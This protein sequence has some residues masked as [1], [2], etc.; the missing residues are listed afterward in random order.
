MVFFFSDL[1]S[2]SKCRWPWLSYTHS[3]YMVTLW[4]D[5][6]KRRTCQSS[7]FVFTPRGKDPLLSN[8]YKIS[9]SKVL[10]RE[11]RNK[12]RIEWYLFSLF[13]YLFNIEI[14]CVK[15]KIDL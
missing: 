12:K 10:L 13:V 7:F 11:R 14:E 9:S 3:V 1:H 2:Y 4:E 5:Q 8:E 6:V 15:G